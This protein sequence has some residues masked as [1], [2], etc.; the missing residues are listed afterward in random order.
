MTKLKLWQ[1]IKCDQTQNV[2]KKNSKTDKTQS[3]QNSNSEREKIKLGQKLAK[4]HFFLNEKKVYFIK[5]FWS[6]TN[7]KLWQNSNFGKTQIVIKLKWW[8][9]S[10]LNQKKIVTKLKFWL[11][12]KSNYISW[13]KYQIVTYKN[14]DNTKIVIKLFFFF[15]K[16]QSI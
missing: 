7:N 13:W 2:R 15:Y 8:E 12:F 4:N 10:N 3:G 1:N 16:T 5:S 11:N 9:N 14:W 6:L